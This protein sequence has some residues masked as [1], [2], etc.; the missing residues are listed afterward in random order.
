MTVVPAQDGPR[1]R[2]GSAG[3]CAGSCVEEGGAAAAAARLCAARRRC[4]W[5]A[6]KGVGRP[7]ERLLSEE[8]PA[9]KTNARSHAATGARKRNRSARRRNAVGFSNNHPPIRGSDSAVPWNGTSRRGLLRG[10]LGTQLLNL[11]YFSSAQFA[12]LGLNFLAAPGLHVTTFQSCDSVQKIRISD[13]HGRG[14]ET[15]FFH[16]ASCRPTSAETR[17]VDAAGRGGRVFCVLRL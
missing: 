3:A 11:Q 13:E 10:L 12:H 14:S 5:H 8:A 2:D 4:I 17:C 7:G 15:P 16:T 1:V 6:W 9:G